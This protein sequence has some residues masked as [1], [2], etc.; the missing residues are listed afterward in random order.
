MCGRAR[1]TIEMVLICQ[2]YRC[3]LVFSD[4]WLVVVVGGAT[5]RRT[6]SHGLV[7]AMLALY[8]LV[9]CL[10]QRDCFSSGDQI[11]GMQRS[12]LLCVL[13]VME[14]VEHLFGEITMHSE[15]STQR[16]VADLRNHQNR[17]RYGMPA[18]LTVCPSFSTLADRYS[19]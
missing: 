11:C 9:F 19:I 2:E 4:L 17:F 1:L 7:R 5:R 3:C 13:A 15:C 6:T 14:V 16:T 18:V 8:G 12:R 10:L